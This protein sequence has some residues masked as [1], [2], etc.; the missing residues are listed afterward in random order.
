[1]ENNM[2]TLKLWEI[3]LLILLFPFFLIKYLG[4]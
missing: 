1:M 4:E 3:G 2:K